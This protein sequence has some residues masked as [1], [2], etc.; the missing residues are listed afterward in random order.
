MNILLG[1]GEQFQA[2]LWTYSFIVFIT[3]LPNIYD[4]E[5]KKKKQLSVFTIGI[6]GIKRRPKEVPLIIHNIEDYIDG[7]K[8]T[9]SVTIWLLSINKVMLPYNNF[10]ILGDLYQVYRSWKGSLISYQ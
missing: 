2:T 10:G 7:C 5:K 3:I 4:K 8:N 6:I 9:F 1:S